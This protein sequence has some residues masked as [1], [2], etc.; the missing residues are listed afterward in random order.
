[1]NSRLQAGDVSAVS[2]RWTLPFEQS[3]FKKGR[4]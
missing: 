4:G 1:M 3:F 2:E